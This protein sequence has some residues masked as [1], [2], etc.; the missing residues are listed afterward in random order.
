MIIS[1]NGKRK[2]S[3]KELKL[4]FNFT[5]EALTDEE[6]I[7]DS[8]ESLSPQEGDKTFT[9]DSKVLQVERA[10]GDIL[11]EP[12]L[13]NLMVVLNAIGLVNVNLSLKDEGKLSLSGVI[14]LEESDKKISKE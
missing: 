1:P 14:E 2:D 10:L 8:F 7:A 9:D 6:P 3:E 13:D 4:A 11:G 5:E 12:S